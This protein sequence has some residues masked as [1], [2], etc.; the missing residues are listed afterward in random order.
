MKRRDFLRTA[1]SLAGLAAL[2]G[3][4]GCSSSRGHETSDDADLRINN[5]APVEVHVY[6]DGS[7]I[8]DVGANNKNYFYVISGTHHVEVRETGDSVYHDLGDHYFG[9]SKVRLVYS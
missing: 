3:L 6:I 1:L 7:H 9:G 5:N 8:G 2:P 4:A